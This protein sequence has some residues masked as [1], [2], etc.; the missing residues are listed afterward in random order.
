MKEERLSPPRVFRVG[1]GGS[2]V[3]SHCANIEMEP[4][5]LVTFVDNAGG[6]YD[7]CRKSWG[8]Y[9]TP[10]VNARLNKF[11]FRCAL[12]MNLKRQLFVMLVQRGKESEFDAYLESE[13]CQVLW[14]LDS[15][16]AVER[17]RSRLCSQD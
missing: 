12:V 3:L 2:I 8:Y 9:A 15:D 7:V 4:D 17:L 1:E 6:E 5:E 14:W 10:S 11:G 13:A 16:E